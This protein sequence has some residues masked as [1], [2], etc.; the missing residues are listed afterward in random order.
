M[1][2]MLQ[3]WVTEPLFWLVK[4]WDLQ[5]EMAVGE[6]HT[7]SSCFGSV[8]EALSPRPGKR[9]LRW[10]WLG[11]V[12]TGALRCMTQPLGLNMLSAWGCRFQ[13]PVWFFVCL[14][15]WVFFPSSLSLITTA[16]CWLQ[17]VWA[18]LSHGE[19]VWQSLNL[20]L[21]KSLLGFLISTKPLFSCI[22][23]KECQSTVQSI[24]WRPGCLQQT[25]RVLTY[26]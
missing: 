4:K 19:H 1:Q 10:A 6:I 25:E 13:T 7:S 2:I 11:K 8:L 14:F 12:G 15:F 26:P 24:T 22:N 17:F 16:T 23:S 5:P 3:S 18:A 9:G 21:S 20:D